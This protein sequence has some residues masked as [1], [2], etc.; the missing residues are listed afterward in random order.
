MAFSFKYGPLRSQ[1]RTCEGYYIFCYL[2][3]FFSH[4]AGARYLIWFKSLVSIEARL[5]G[6]QIRICVRWMKKAAGVAW[7]SRSVV[8]SVGRIDGSGD[9]RNA[10]EGGDNARKMKAV[11]LH[12]PVALPL[13]LHPS[14]ALSPSKTAVLSE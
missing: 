5:P 14:P 8:R 9:A 12:P 10:R 2:L 7:R 13:S 4:N 1:N 6:S 11:P 3:S